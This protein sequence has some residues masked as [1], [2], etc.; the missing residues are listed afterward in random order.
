MPFSLGSSNKPTAP[1]PLSSPV[2]LLC[3]QGS[4]IP[5]QF[6]IRTF[7]ESFLP[8]RALETPLRRKSLWDLKGF[9]GH[10]VKI[11]FHPAEV[12]FEFQWDGKGLIYS[13]DSSLLSFHNLLKG[14]SIYFCES[15]NRNM[16]ICFLDKYISAIINVT[17][18]FFFILYSNAALEEFI[19]KRYTY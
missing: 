11:T 16:Q 14:K 6:Q 17:K 1:G 4:L 3:S 15:V 7:L 13:R 8:F 2:P 19:Y 12:Q 9:T 10:F 5:P 18:H